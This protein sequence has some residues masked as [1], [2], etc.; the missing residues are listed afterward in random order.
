M[1]ALREGGVSN[2]KVCDGCGARIGAGQKSA[3]LSAP[4][5]QADACSHQCLRAIVSGYT[6]T[7][8]GLPFLPPKGA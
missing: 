2:T 7:V 5:C 4:D 6:A 3:H 1:R 8:S